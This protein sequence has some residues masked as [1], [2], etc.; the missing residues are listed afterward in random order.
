[1]VDIL[2]VFAGVS[3]LPGKPINANKRKVKGISLKPALSPAAKRKARVAPN[4][5]TP[6]RWALCIG[7]I[8][9]GLTTTDAV[10]L[11]GI[12]RVLLNGFLRTDPRVRAQ[13]EEAKLAALR[14]AWDIDTIEGIMADIAAGHTIKKC[15]EEKRGL[16]REAFFKLALADPLIK[17]MYD[18]ARKVQAETMSDDIVEIA[19]EDDGD[20]TFDGKGNSANVNRSRLKVDTRK[21]IMAAVHHKRWAAKSSH[22]H[23][24][25]VIVDHAAR[26]EE[27]R[28]RAEGV[29]DVTPPKGRI[30]FSSPSEGLDAEADA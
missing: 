21:Y 1:M 20:M 18:E 4:A 16:S 10:E 12:P 6:E 17:E 9:E 7:Y 3:L 14:N 19:D 8:C 25:K 22:E 30:E 26:L 27:A 24:H 15:V 5:F 2:R 13:W 11:A 23:D 28:A 29:I